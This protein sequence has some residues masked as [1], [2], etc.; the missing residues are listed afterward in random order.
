MDRHA[1]GV[2]KALGLIAVAYLSNLIYQV[3]RL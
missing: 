2:F 1:V 3:G